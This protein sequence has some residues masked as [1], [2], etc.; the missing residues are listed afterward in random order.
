MKVLSLILT[1]AYAITVICCVVDI[2]KTRRGSASSALWL[3]IVM[4]IP[5]GF[6]AYIL[7]G[8]SSKERKQKLEATW[9]ADAE[10]KEKANLG[11]LD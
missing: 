8:D 4:I 5:F 3:F 11:T 1:L 6:L 10:L 7:F 2:L 9:R